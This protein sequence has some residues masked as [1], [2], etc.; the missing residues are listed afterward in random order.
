MLSHFYFLLKI[1]RYVAPYYLVLSSYSQSDTVSDGVALL[2]GWWCKWKPPEISCE[3]EMCFLVC[4]SCISDLMACGDCTFIAI[5]IKRLFP[6]SYSTF[7][8]PCN[9]ISSCLFSCYL[10]LATH[11]CVGILVNCTFVAQFISF[12]Q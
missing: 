9:C 10:H 1:T 5:H 7:F 3:N 12:Y 11:L 2:W 6:F 8:C 4:Y